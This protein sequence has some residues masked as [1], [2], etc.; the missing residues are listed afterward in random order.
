MLI[1][2]EVTRGRPEN[3][4][5]QLKKKNRCFLLLI[6]PVR[7]I[8]VVFPGV[9]TKCGSTGH[10]VGRRANMER[11]ALVQRME[12]KLTIRAQYI[13]YSTDFLKGLVQNK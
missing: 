11:R 10:C 6:L 9:H 13:V 12:E 3:P 2:R 1:L 8:D 5:H 7:C 4:Q